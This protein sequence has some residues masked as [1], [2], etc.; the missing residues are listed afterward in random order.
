MQTACLIIIGN[1]ILSG[2]TQEKNCA[3]IA[4]E[5][6]DTGVRLTEVRVIPDD[7]PTIIQ[8]VN[9]CRSHFTYIFTTGGI[10]PTHD[11]IT[12]AAIAKAF[13]VK[14]ERNAEAVALLER[15]YTP[16][17]LNPAR[18]KMA[19]IPAGATL[20]LNPVSAA[21]GYRIENVYVLAGV[22]AI[23]QAMFAGIKYQFR[24]DAKMLTKTVSAHITEGVIAE[25]L[26]AIQNQYP[27]VEIGS[28]PLIHQQKLGVSLVAR[29]IDPA[30]L[31]AAYSAIKALLLTLTPEIAEEDWAA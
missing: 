8:A 17:N 14:L 25:K 20:I 18:L 15:H 5:L 31:D 10:G 29:A 21:P 9:S 12:S 3:W 11:D 16:E 23:M 22:P 6:N 19:E 30:R 2:R 27:D 1:E 7:E 28:Y 13:G 4:K 26:A 24:G